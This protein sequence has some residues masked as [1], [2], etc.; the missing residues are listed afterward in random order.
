MGF[1]INSKTKAQIC[2]YCHGPFHDHERIVGCNVCNTT[3]HYDCFDKKC[4]NLFCHG[5]NDLKT[6]RLCKGK[7][8]VH[9]DTGFILPLFVSDICYFCNGKG[10]ELKEICKCENGCSVCLG[11][12]I[13]PIEAK[14]RWSIFRDNVC[15]C[16]D[17]PKWDT[18]ALKKTF[19]HDYYQQKRKNFK[20]SSFESNMESLFP[21]LINKI[22]YFIAKIATP[23][24]LVSEYF[25]KLE[26]KL[27]SI[28]LWEF[29][30]AVMFLTVFVYIIFIFV[31]VG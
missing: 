1:K 21:M 7:G 2:A 13:I 26:T 22:S 17:P 6:C 24:K 11:K 29:E 12:Q 25:M 3:I 20:I 31:Y 23:L 15:T 28:F 5:F 19:D 4:P 9:Q 14:C 8:K 27:E 18:L 16:Y 10:V 30:H